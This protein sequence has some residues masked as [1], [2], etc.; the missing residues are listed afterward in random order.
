MQTLEKQ[1]RLYDVAR[2]FQIIAANPAKTLD[3][4][5]EVVDDTTIK[6][7][8]SNL[9]GIAEKLNGDPMARE[10]EA[11]L[12]HPMM[13]SPPLAVVHARDVA[14]EGELPPF[15]WKAIQKP[16]A[17]LGDL[18]A[19]FECTWG[20]QALKIVKNGAAD[21]EGF[22]GGVHFARSKFKKSMRERLEK[23]AVKRANA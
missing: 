7:I 20:G 16:G 5:L 6:V 21:Y 10:I 8:E 4:A 2:A 19:A 22:I 1:V 17:A 23:E 13:D 3:L 14:K 12:S 18:N 15:K 11:L 9:H